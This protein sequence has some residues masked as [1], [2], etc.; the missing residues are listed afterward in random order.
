MEWNKRS[1]SFGFESTN[2]DTRTTLPSRRGDSFICISMEKLSGSHP[3]FQTLSL[4]R[5][6]ST[7]RITSSS[8]RRRISHLEY[9]FMLLVLVLFAKLLH[10]ITTAPYYH[11]YF[12]KCSWIYHAN[13]FRLWIWRKSPFFL[14]IFMFF[15]SISLY[16]YQQI[17][18]QDILSFMKIHL[19]VSSLLC[20]VSFSHALNVAESC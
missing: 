5:N 11:A 6:C 14:L 15:S 10:D 7:S 17:Q 16:F 3:S 4:W 13:Q 12:W 9:N 1:I 18:L 20:V 19:I 2:F 8:S